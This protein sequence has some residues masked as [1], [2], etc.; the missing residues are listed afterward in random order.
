MPLLVTPV[1]FIAGAWTRSKTVELMY[2][3]R[4]TQSVAAHAPIRIAPA[5]S[6]NARAIA[7]TV[8]AVVER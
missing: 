7:V 1:A 2:S 3:R 4:L 8:A 5:A 6:A